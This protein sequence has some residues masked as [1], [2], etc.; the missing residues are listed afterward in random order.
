MVSGIVG[1]TRKLK[2]KIKWNIPKFRSGQFSLR[3]RVN[4]KLTEKYNW[5]RVNKVNIEDENDENVNEPV[6]N[7]EKTMKRNK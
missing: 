6:N 7:D 5:F 1:F 3:T 4:K 2:R